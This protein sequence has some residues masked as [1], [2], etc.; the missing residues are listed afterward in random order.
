MGRRIVTGERGPA[1]VSLADVVTMIR[2]TTVDVPPKSPATVRAI[3]IDPERG[4]IEEVA[5]AANR[6]GLTSLL[7]GEIGS[8]MRVPGNDHVLSRLPGVETPW[9]WRKDDLTFASR[10]VIVGRDSETDHFTDLVTSIE[11]LRTSVAFRAPN[12][13]RWTSYAE[14]VHADRPPAA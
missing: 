14:R 2:W 10:S 12:E 1:H 13:S 6:L 4:L 5:I 11:N 8:Y 9:C 3:L 7:G